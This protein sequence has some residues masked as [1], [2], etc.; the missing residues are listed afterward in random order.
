MDIAKIDPNFLVSSE[1]EREGLEWHRLPE[2]P[3]SICGLAVAEGEDF[4]RLPLD[5]VNEVND[6]V[7]TL[8]WHLAGGRIRFRTNSRFIAFRGK[9]RYLGSGMPHM[10]LTGISGVDVHE[11]GGSLYAIKPQNDQKEWFEGIVNCRKAEGWKDIDIYLPLYNGLTVMMVGL[12]EGCQIAAPKPFALDKP[13][14]YYGSSITQGGCAS[15][16]GNSY[17][18]FLSRWLNADQINLG[19]SGNGKGE[20]NMAQYIAG[21]DMCA[22]VFDYDY[23]A[24]NAEHL[25]ATHA[26]F[27]DIVRAAHPDIPILM[28]T[29]P[30]FDNVIDETAPR[31]VEIKKSFRRALDLGDKNVYYFDGTDLVGGPDSHDCT[32]D[33][34]HPNDLGFYR[35]A[36]ALYPTL[37]KT[38]K[39]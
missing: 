10:P 35:M 26:P 28:M 25:R 37:A 24:P 5:L 18:G 36:Q 38:L 39:R 21:L 7:K 15:K 30:E 4:C 12:E 20:T 2:S 32:T 19:F 8:G 22:F 17:Q 14:V 6:G 16:P 23:N 11:D 31:R 1:I 13:I 33:D 29:H 27:Y 3:F 34:C 9:V